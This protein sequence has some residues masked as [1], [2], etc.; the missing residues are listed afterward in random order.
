MRE[1]QF[2]SREILNCYEDD[3]VVDMV[4]RDDYYKDDLARIIKKEIKH[5]DKEDQVVYNDINDP[6]ILI[7]AYRMDFGDSEIISLLVENGLSHD[8]ACLIDDDY[9]AQT[10]EPE[11]D[12]D[13]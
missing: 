1:L 3:Y 2:E 9:S 6:N 13:R 4:I 7:N 8:I 5:F 10:Y 12:Y 11:Y